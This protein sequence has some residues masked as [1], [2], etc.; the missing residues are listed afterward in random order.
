LG[1]FAIHAA[2]HKARPDVGC[3]I[4]NHTRAGMAVSMM[5][6]GL[7]PLSQHAMAFYGRVGY[8]DNSGLALDP[9]AEMAGIAESMGDN[10]V[11]I[12]RNH[13]TLV[14]GATISEAFAMLSKLEAAMAAQ[15]DALATGEELVYGT[16]EL[17][18]HIAS[19]MFRGT[20]VPDPEHAEYVAL[21]AG[22]YAPP[23]GWFE[24]PALIRMID[25]ID[26]S[27]KD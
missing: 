27:Y 8:H 16:P 12:L 25:R 20:I 19:F 22:K 2:I 15:V 7:L 5:K 21:E 23:S 18:K 14:A 4:H 1:G 13:G 3:V 17:A 26:P 24:W 6:R 10:A 11:L 9:A